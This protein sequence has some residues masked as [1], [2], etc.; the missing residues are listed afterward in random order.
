[1]GCRSTFKGNRKNPRLKRQAAATSSNHD[2]NFKSIFKGAHHAKA[3]WPLQRKNLGAHFTVKGAAVK[4]TTYRLG[5]GNRGLLPL[6]S[7]I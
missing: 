7:G 2:G 4:A 3:G 1:M 5:G 6:H